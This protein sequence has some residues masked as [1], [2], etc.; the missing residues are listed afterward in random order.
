MVDRTPRLCMKSVVVVISIL[1]F[2][3]SSAWWMHDRLTVDS[4]PPTQP[5]IPSR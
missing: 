2:L 3:L 1:V 4:H 5:F